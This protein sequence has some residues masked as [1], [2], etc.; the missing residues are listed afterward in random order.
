MMLLDRFR[1]IPTAVEVP[2]TRPVCNPSILAVE[3]GWVV[4]VRTLDPVP[5]TGSGHDYLSS[6]NWLIRYDREL[7]PL[8][9]SK[10]RDEA[11]VERCPQARNGLEDGR[12]FTW[13]GQL[14]ALFSGLERHGNAFFNTMVLTRVEGDRLTDPVV[15]PSPRRQNR[16]K[17]WMPWVLDGVLYFIYSTQPMEV[18]RF[19]GTRLQ[20]AHHGARAFKGMKGLMSGSS[21]VIP[22][23]E[24][25]LAVTHQRNR[26]PLATRLIQ[27]YVTHDPDYQ[28]KKVRF[29]HYLL[30]LDRHF[31]VKGH[32]RAF[33]F[34]TEGI[35]FCAGMAYREGRLLISYGVMD[36]KAR[37]LE[38]DPA[39]V[40]GM[41][42]LRPRP[43]NLDRTAPPVSANAAPVAVDL[44]VL[45]YRNFNTTAA[46]CLD[47]L[48]PQ[49]AACPSRVRMQLLDNGSPDSSPS[50]IVSYARGF[51]ELAYECLSE[52]LGFAGGMNHAAKR[53]SAEWLLLV[54]NDTVFAPGSLE[55]LLR[56]LASASLDVAAV[57]PVT[58]AAGN[59]QDYFLEGGAE[60]VLATAALFSKHPVR[61]LFPVYR[62]DFFCVAVRR[63][64]WE[65]LGGLD[66]AFGLG[67]YEDFD[68]SVRARLAGYRLMM[69][70]DAFVYH[71]GGASFKQSANTKRLIRANR[72]LFTARYPEVALPHKREGNLATLKLY[73]E[74]LRSGEA[75]TPYMERIALRKW[76][77]ERAMPKS[78][79]KRRQ[80]KKAKAAL[81]L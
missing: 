79:S 43:R 57:G 48:R 72:D 66:P 35:E 28:R 27:K 34:E 80:W 56:A 8:S 30:L 70:E 41:V 47:S 14:W 68:F 61:R 31:N 52:N 54:N 78:F 12:L 7:R 39:W 21:Q 40:D 29:S 81:L 23:G 58:N 77:L 11:V 42:G 13:S 45:N 1:L 55:H 32:S 63:T 59:E 3:E 65:M 22:W 37:L 6:E 38:L 75:A 9:K 15:I 74:L 24:H 67:Y 17:N 76:A 10:L 46:R 36:E 18:Y 26:A 16:E 53:G 49:L 69:C 60:E 71:Q 73:E 64:V 51:P 62:L 44:I 33:S 4:L 5:Y 2:T 25:Y 19:D 20:P 50:D